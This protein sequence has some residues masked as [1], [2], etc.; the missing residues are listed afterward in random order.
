MFVQCLEPDNTYTK[1]SK[2]FKGKCIKVIVA[3]YVTVMVTKWLYQT[4]LLEICFQMR[5]LLLTEI[6]FE[7][8]KL[9]GLYFVELFIFQ[10][11]FTRLA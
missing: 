10:L 1:S 5:Y 9:C 8:S 4:L 2:L 11:L 7:H 6:T 3:L